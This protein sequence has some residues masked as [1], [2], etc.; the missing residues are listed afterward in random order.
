MQQLVNKKNFDNMKMHATNVKNL[1]TIT[2]LTIVQNL[3]YKVGQTAVPYTE[4]LK[5]FSPSGLQRH[6]LKPKIYAVRRI[7]LSTPAE[8][9]RTANF[10]SKSRLL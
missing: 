6:T 8:N 7:V 10:L 2:G 1:T 3:Y 9:Y 4:I 5:S